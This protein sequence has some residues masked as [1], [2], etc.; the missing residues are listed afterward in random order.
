MK[1]CALVIIVGAL[2]VASSA[3]PVSGSGGSGRIAFSDRFWPKNVK[4]TD[5]WEIFVV[6]PAGGARRN[7]SLSPYCNETSPAWS[8]DGGEIAFTCGFGNPAMYVM[9]DDG[10][11]RRR[12]P[13]SR[14]AYHL[15]WSPDGRRIA[16]LSRGW[17]STIGIDGRGL[18]RVTREG[19]SGLSWSPDGRKIAFVR[20]SGIFV[21]NVDGSGRR[22]LTRSRDDMLPAWSPDGRKIVFL[23]DLTSLGISDRQVTV[24]NADGT[25][26]HSISAPGL[27]A[28]PAWQ[29]RGVPAGG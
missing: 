22:R 10:R 4:I 3:A 26:A 27:H 21:V 15:S 16:F 19:G 20:P 18:R 28:V 1:L 2:S 13:K 25:G 11:L 23:R 17:L 7:L 9:R 14:P 29:P 6:N 5:N 8:P 24:M 12:V